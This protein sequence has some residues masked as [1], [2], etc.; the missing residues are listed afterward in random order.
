VN[1][2]NRVRKLEDAVGGTYEPTHIVV[3]FI[4]PIRG[5]V[6]ALDR[7]TDTWFERGD[8]EPEDLFADRVRQSTEDRQQPAKRFPW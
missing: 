6:S 1:Y 3:H 5:M 4:D 7:M 8:D 2:A